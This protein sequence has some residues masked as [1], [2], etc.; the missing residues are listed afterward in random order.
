MTTLNVKDIYNTLH[1]M[2]ELGHQEFKTSAYLADELGKLGYAI[3]RNIGVTGVVGEI[4][5]AEPAPCFCSAQIWMPFPSPSTASLSAF[6]PAAM[7]LTALCCWL[8]L[9]F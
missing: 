6:M 1:Q 7:T 8:P 9:P 2:P 4:K 5:G 3:T